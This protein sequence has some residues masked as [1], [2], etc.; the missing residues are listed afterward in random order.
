MSITKAQIVVRKPVVDSDG[1]SGG[2]RMSSTAI[3]SGIKNNILPNVTLSERAAGV[4]R[5]RK[6]FVHITNAEELTLIEPK[7]FLD[8][9]SV[10]DDAVMIFNGTQTD[11][12]ADLTGT[13]RLYGAGKLDVSVVVGGQTIK[14]LTEGAAFNYI[15]NG[16]K[17]R[18]SDMATVEAVTGNEQYA[19]VSSVPTYAGDVATFTITE[20]LQYNFDAAT[21][22]V[23][24]LLPMSD[25][26][27]SVT[28]LVV[29]TAGSGDFNNATNPIQTFNLSTI[30]QNWT[31]T[32]KSGGTQ[33]NVAGDTVGDL[34]D[35][36]V[37]TDISPANPV[38][39]S[40]YF[41]LPIAGLTGSFA[42][43]DTIAFTTVPNS[44]GIWFKQVV[45]PATNNLAGNSFRL[46]I[47][48]E[49]AQ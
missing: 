29:N 46:G 34:G 33:V 17:I 2:G 35:F 4:T 20:T 10:G 25:M 37:S 24:S 12:I 32:F 30:Q 27:A 19:T 31:L 1:A 15:R 6:R 48:G 16:D 5:L 49:S 38:L 21:T 8:Q 44:Q 43:G 13:E 47:V 36:S 39:L 18:I 9:Y 3:T 28:S 41:T 26:K 22:R 11:T 7:I 45:A 23:A 40:A 14:V 42:N